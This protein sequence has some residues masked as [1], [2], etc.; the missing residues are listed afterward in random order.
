VKVRS[1]I[2]AIVAIAIAGIV[3]F[4]FGARRPAG[5]IPS[6]AAPLPVSAA[7]SKGF[8][9]FVE[10]LSPT[11]YYPLDDTTST[12]VDRSGKHNDG[13]YMGA[14]AQSSTPL[15]SDGEA[16]TL[17][18]G[19]SAWVQDQ[20][21][22]GVPRVGAELAYSEMVL[23]KEKKPSAGGALLGFDS[24][25][26]IVDSGSRNFGLFETD[27]GEMSLV[28]VDPTGS[29]F[30]ITT[31]GAY[32]DG[33]T[34]LVVAE[35]S[36]SG[37]TPGSTV[38]MT[39]YVSNDLGGIDSRT[40][41]FPVK[42]PFLT[43]GFTHWN[44]GALEISAVAPF[45]GA[46]ASE[47][48]DGNLAKAALFT[49]VLTR[50]QVERIQSLVGTAANGPKRAANTAPVEQTARAAAPKRAAQTPESTQR[51]ISRIGFDTHFNY[52]TTP[53]RTVDSVPA[54]V[55]SLGFGLGLR[56]GGSRFNTILS[57]LFATHHL[58]RS[59]MFS[60]LASHPAPTAEVAASVA[61]VGGCGHIAWFETD[62]E[63]DDWKTDPGYSSWFDEAIAD[64]KALYAGAKAAC[65]GVPV[66]TTPLV[67]S[68]DVFEIAGEANFADAANTHV[69]PACGQ[70]PEWNDYI[71]RAE[72]PVTKVFPGKPIWNTEF[73]ISVYEPFD[74]SSTCQF[75]DSV[76]A[77]YESRIFPYR[78]SYVKEA[79]V[80]Q[81]QAV[82]TPFDRSFGST[83]VIDRFGNYK[84]QAYALRT[85]LGILPSTGSGT[86][87]TA[88]S[89]PF[90][91]VP[92][93]YETLLYD[94]AT[95]R[96]YTLLWLG[97]ASGP[98]TTFR[99]PIPLP[100]AYPLQHPRDPVTVS[101]PAG[102]TEAW[103]GRYADST[104]K[105]L[106]WSKLTVSGGQVTL[107]G[108]N[109]VQDE[110]GFLVSGHGAWTPPSPLPVLA[111]GLSD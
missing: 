63:P 68:S 60:R 51:F 64:Q 56:D 10:S 21:S 54:A 97:V 41:T 39:L 11:I 8:D 79:A 65:P 36:L 25:G 84:P 72:A 16:S 90:G 85:E 45:R 38:T 57:T 110:T 103:W 91:N 101:L 77:R 67:T 44:V 87:S 12:A 100:T 106:A 62:N 104:F 6:E 32:N 42:H 78:L 15:T 55:A 95:C 92:N 76:A 40:Q 80:L 34:H 108:E 49:G 3:G 20:T 61:A 83:G 46:P 23:E 19:S 70:Y 82:D 107:S 88:Y 73:N 52:P 111:P 1:G 105:S 89:A 13:A 33:K 24:V 22:A 26:S 94:A 59:L 96:H 5:P 50:S 27:T 86:C 69:S 47:Y 37:T 2:A 74:A 109:A 58:K 7:A 81:Y 30:R 4:E 17:F 102:D 53:Y 48:F 99:P 98:A 29:A 9:A 35:V 43:F 14:Y 93:V 75:S 66:L 71:E 18:D 28:M 31:S